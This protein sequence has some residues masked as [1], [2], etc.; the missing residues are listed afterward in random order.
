ML[1]YLFTYLDRV[2]DI[3]GAG[4]FQYISF[5]AALS[6]ILSL[7]ISLIYGKRII[8]FLRESR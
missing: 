4:M 3:P 2:Y 5:R 6:T 8:N 7:F 1:Y